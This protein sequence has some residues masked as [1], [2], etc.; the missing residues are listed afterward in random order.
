MRQFPIELIG[1]I[2]DDEV[3]WNSFR[4]RRRVPTAQ[5]NGH[6]TRIYL[7]KAQRTC[8]ISFPLA[9]GSWLFVI[10]SQVFPLIDNSFRIVVENRWI[11]RIGPGAVTNISRS[12]RKRCIFGYHGSPAKS[13]EF[14]TVFPHSIEL[15]WLPCSPA[16]HGSVYNKLPFYQSI[17]RELL[18]TINR[19]T[20]A[21]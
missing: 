4:W 3:P 15:P 21:R 14:G 6:I 13:V 20:K 7:S 19:T 18:S 10:P 8:I 16:W 2:G 11:R 12:F 5:V 9:T 17:V 1:V